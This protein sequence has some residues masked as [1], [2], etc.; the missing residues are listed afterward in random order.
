MFKT[1]YNVEEHRLMLRPFTFNIKRAL[2]GAVQNQH[3]TYFS[4]D[5]LT[6][7]GTTARCFT[8]FCQLLKHILYFLSFNSSHHKA[9]LIYTFFFF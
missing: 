8:V 1:D 4:S 5:C 3:N 7:V 9:F 2:K 6:N